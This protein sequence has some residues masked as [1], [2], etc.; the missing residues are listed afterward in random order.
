MH[1][2]NHQD[3]RGGDVQRGG[4]SRSSHPVTRSRFVGQSYWTVIDPFMFMAACGVQ[5]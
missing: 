3:A 4:C 5:M 1:V 2:V